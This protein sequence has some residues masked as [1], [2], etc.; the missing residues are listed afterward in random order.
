MSLLYDQN[1]ITDIDNNGTEELTSA[2]NPNWFAGTGNE[3]ARGAKNIVTLGQRVAGQM[4]ST[5]ANALGVNQ[6]LTRDNKVAQIHDITPT[7]PE[8]L[9]KYEK[10]DAAN[11]GA[12]AIILGDLFEQTPIIAGAIINPLAGFAAGAAYGADHGA[13]EAAD[14]NITG[15]AGKYYAAIRALEFGVGGAIP[16]VG[17]I[18]ERALL[19]Y[20]S[21]FVT[22]GALNVGMMEGSKWGRAEVLDAFGY[23]DQAAQIR[24][25][26][27]QAAATAFLMGGFFNLAGGHA[28][29]RDLPTVTEQAPTPEATPPAGAVP[30]DAAISDTPAP[31]PVVDA[32]PASTPLA[33]YKLSRADVKATKSEIVNS[34]RHL[35]R[36]DA[37]R[38]AVLADPLKGSGKALARAREAQQARLAEIETQRQNSLAINDAA[39]ER[40]DSHEAYGRQRIDALHVDAATHTVLQDNYVTESAPGLA[41]DTLSESAHVR[42]MD[43]ATDAIHTGRAVDVSAHFENDHG[44]I[45]NQDID[46]GHTDRQALA[47]DTTARIDRTVAAASE[48]S[49]PVSPPPDS[50]PGAISDAIAEPF[51]M[52]RAQMQALQET[53]PDLASALAPHIDAI[54]AEHNL[55]HAEAQQFDIAAACAL[56]SGR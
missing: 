23:S 19:K 34:Q 41:V 32:E 11:S 42:A 47:G 44:F 1:Q 46:A 51:D 15:P 53:H 18:G 48:Q 24:Q 8:D 38:A 54:Q 36:L 5:A 20:G 50:I 43:A 21:R 16:G 49:L 39:R 55:S 35:D 56:V 22:G 28:R 17:G 37:E 7:A 40:L 25:W 13:E 10:P 30:P 26:D 6:Y 14:M 33:G 2:S 12:A 31:T 52:L 9:P 3:L 27:T 29:E 4:D 45:V